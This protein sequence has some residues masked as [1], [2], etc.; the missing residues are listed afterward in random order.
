MKQ[1]M[2]EH[3]PADNEADQIAN[4]AAY[5]G[6]WAEFMGVDVYDTGPDS[7]HEGLSEII[8]DEHYRREEE[9][10]QAQIEADYADIFEEDAV[11]PDPVLVELFDRPKRIRSDQPVDEELRAMYAHRA[12]YLEGDQASDEDSVDDDRNEISDE[13]YLEDISSEDDHYDPEY[14]DEDPLEG[15]VDR[16]VDPAETSDHIGYDTAHEANVARQHGDFTG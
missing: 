11:T 6:K 7:E 9:A 16:W 4:D 1:A 14:E 8:L 10:E 12:A 3:T 5:D 2:H 13:S 15:D